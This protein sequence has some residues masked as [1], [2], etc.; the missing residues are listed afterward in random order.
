MR[1][2]KE[3]FQTERL[4]C[5]LW[6]REDLE[7]IY[8]VYSD[9]EGSR[10]V[11]DGQ[12][13]SREETIRWLDVTFNNYTTR[14]YGMSTVLEKAT[15]DIVGFCGLVHPDG[16]QLAE[17]KY[18]FKRT[19]WGLG[20]ASEIVPGMISYGNTVHV[21]RKSSQLLQLKTAHLSVYYKNRT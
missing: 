19:H 17:I 6:D 14:G 12:P 7:A 5:R 4:I 21:L 1:V 9:E 2:A 10:W 13:I 8:S 18:S 3:I 20:Y 15:G 16:Q 11:G